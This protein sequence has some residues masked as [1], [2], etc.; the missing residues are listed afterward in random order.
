MNVDGEK[1][2]PDDSR[3]ARIDRI[4]KEV[5]AQRYAGQ[6]VSFSEIERQ[7]SKLMPQLGA[8]L[9]TLGA[10]EAAAQQ[11]RQT[12]GDGQPGDQVNSAHEAELAFLREELHGYDIIERI[13][14]GGQGAVYRAIQHSPKRTVAVKLLLDGPLASDRQRHRFRQ[15]VDLASRVRHP[16]IVTVYE[17]GVVQGRHFFT[18]DFIEGLPIDDYALLH[19]LPVRDRVHLFAKICR[20]VSTAHQHGIIH[21]DLK[22]SNILVDSEGEPHIL[23]FGLAKDVLFAVAEDG[24]KGI[25]LTGQVVG[26]LPYLSPE[27]AAGCSSQVDIRAD[28]YS[29]GVI[30]YRLV[31]THFPYPVD[32]DRI[33]V[34]SNICTREAVSLRKVLSREDITDVP[35]AG[36]IN[37]DLERVLFKALEKDKSRRYQ[38]AAAFGED[39]ERYLAGEAVDAKSASNL[40]LLKKTIRRLRVQFAIAGC[41]VAVLVIALI[42]LAVAWRHTARVAELYQAGLQMG[43]YVRL[44]SA[45]RDEGRMDDA[46]AQFETALEIYDEVPSTDTRIQ[47]RRYD[48]HHQLAEMYYETGD[49]GDAES[50]RNAALQIAQELVRDD[51]QNPEWQRILAFAYVLRGRAAM[52]GDEWKRALDDLEKASPIY[53]A[54]VSSDGTNARKQYDLAFVQ[55]L[56]G[57]CYRRLEQYEKAYSQYTAAYEIYRAL[58]EA[59]PHVLDYVIELARTEIKLGV[60]HFNQRTVDHDRQASHWFDRAADRLSRLHD[61]G[62]DHG[63]AWDIR[64]LLEDIEVNRR[65][66]EQRIRTTSGDSTSSDH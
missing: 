5:M 6:D 53:Q 39:L 12:P 17:S 49:P 44:G 11:A 41:F 15:E 34:L 30:L 37:D 21:R 7:H 48:A 32:G 40:Y 51:A 14:R 50:H 63:R 2:G 58:A 35:G 43:S 29:L 31:T 20:A 56:M 52:S 9:R 28:I 60:W 38:S 57:K 4:V 36:W 62:R 3:C 46:V 10:I 18:M 59:E 8:R 45:A 27:Q 24:V 65:L 33:A 19:N 42:A 1:P 61:A 25:S 26:T 64:R 16:N 22:P 66:L 54:L 47:R 23:D 13:Y 55:R